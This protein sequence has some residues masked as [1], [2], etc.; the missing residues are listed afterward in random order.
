MGKSHYT[1]YMD[2]RLKDPVYHYV[3]N[4]HNS[5]VDLTGGVTDVVKGR[6]DPYVSHG[7]RGEGPVVN[8][9][10]QKPTPVGPPTLPF[11]VR[12]V[13]GSYQAHLDFQPLGGE[14]TLEEKVTQVSL[15]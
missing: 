8:T 6:D 1:P 10:T 14:T 9:K 3:T 12:S 13:Q 2:L 15:R 7:H 11:E 4:L 5:L